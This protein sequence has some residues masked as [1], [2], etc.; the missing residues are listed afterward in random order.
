MGKGCLT[1]L[2]IPTA[3]DKPHVG[4]G[5]VRG[6]ERTGD[7]ERTIPRELSGHGINLGNLK[8]FLETQGRQHGG[9]ALG[10]HGLA[11]TGGPDE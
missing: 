2:G 4:N 8:G 9:D 7:H 3:A 6:T 1:R 5:V 10:E 11:R